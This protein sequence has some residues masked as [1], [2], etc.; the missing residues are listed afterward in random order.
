[1]QATDHRKETDGSSVYID[2]VIMLTD[3]F[4]IYID[5]SFMLGSC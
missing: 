1:M 2:I 3:S 5:G 4:I